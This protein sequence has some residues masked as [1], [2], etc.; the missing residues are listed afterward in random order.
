[1]SDQHRLTS[2]LEVCINTGIGF[3]VSFIF[4]PPVA[5][6]MGYPYSLADNFAI[7]GIF[8]VLSIARG[9]IIRRFFAQGLHNT[10]ARWARRLLR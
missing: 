3:W 1:M 6:V 8:T 5:A 9:Y 2:L 4:W 7:T 10:A